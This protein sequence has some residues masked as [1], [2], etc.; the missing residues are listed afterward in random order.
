MPE[1]LGLAQTAFASQTQ[2]RIGPEGVFAARAVPVKAPRE[3][4]K[5][6]KMTVSRLRAARPLAE[7]VAE[8]PAV[9]GIKSLCSQFV[10]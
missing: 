1:N 3:R 8:S 9:I 7:L 5:S 4:P 10:I 6:W 2:H